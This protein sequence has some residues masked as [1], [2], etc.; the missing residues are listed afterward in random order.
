[1]HWSFRIAQRKFW[2]KSITNL[3]EHKNDLKKFDVLSK[4]R[5]RDGQF[6]L[7]LNG[8]SCGGKSSVSDLLFE[9]Y[10]GL[11]K[12]K[13]DVIKWLISDYQP[14]IHRG[15][16]HRMTLETLRVALSH[17]LSILQEGAAW[18]P[19]KYVE[20]SKEA[21]IPLFVANIEAPWEVLLSRFEMRIAAQNHGA[22]ISNVDPKRF[23]EL[24]DMYLKTKMET[25]M[26]FDSSKESPEQIARQIVS[27]IRSH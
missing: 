25:E 8:P 2:L 3:I 6:F 13:S 18:E 24:Y 11:F 7:I 15:I 5:L 1:M 16:V 22:R 14:S 26:E 23:Q 21:K 10:G 17:G 19:E 9:R 12:G 20:L 4:E 27:Y